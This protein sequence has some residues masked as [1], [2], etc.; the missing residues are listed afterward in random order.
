MFSLKDAV[1]KTILAVSLAA[2]TTSF[3]TG[4]NNDQP[5]TS[6]DLYPP[7]I[8]AEAP[9]SLTDDIDPTD[10]TTPDANTFS[11]KFKYWYDNPDVQEVQE[12]I[13]NPGGDDNG[14]T[15]LDL[16]GL[17]IYTDSDGNEYIISGRTPVY[18]H[19]GKISQVEFRRLRDENGNKIY[20]VANVDGQGP[21]D[22]KQGIKDYAEKMTEQTKTYEERLNNNQQTPDSLAGQKIYLNNIDTLGV[23]DDNNMIQLA[24]LFSSPLSTASFLTVEDDQVDAAIYLSAAGGEIQIYLKRTESGVDITYSNIST[25]ASLTDK[26]VVVYDDTS[27]VMSPDS[28]EDILGFD[29]EFHDEYINIVTDVKD[30]PLA[31]NIL[32]KSCNPGSITDTSIETTVDDE[33]YPIP[34]SNPPSETPEDAK[35]EEKPVETQAKPANNKTP[36]GKYDLAASDIINKD[37]TYT[38]NEFNPDSIPAW[39]A[40]SRTAEDWARLESKG[41]ESNPSQIPYSEITL[42]NAKDAFPFLGYTGQVPEYVEVLPEDS[43]AIIADKVYDN[44]IGKDPREWGTLAPYHTYT[45]KAEHDAALAEEQRKIDEEIKR[46]QE[47]RAD[48]E[49][50]ETIGGRGSEDF[51]DDLLN[52]R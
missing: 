30:L 31:G 48:L 26:D 40:S 52:S 38:Q 49:A 13:P 29:V 11:I 24:D 33:K 14:E 42:E 36:D 18:L 5:I 7:T 34:H 19:N 32:D 43:D 25:K 4:C 16:A 17:P 22:V 3:F 12:R 21:E 44:L 1:R 47:G 51:Y 41:Y 45:S 39:S 46:Q 37:G 28:I 35:P 2:V 8:T 10:P 9:P 27:I 50:G 23:V 20:Y 15:F 6:S